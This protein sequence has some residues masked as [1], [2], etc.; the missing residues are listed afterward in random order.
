MS[1]PGSTSINV[2]NWCIISKK[3]GELRIVNT[4]GQQVRVYQNSI[5]LDI[6]FCLPVI[7]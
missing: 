5:P 2:G 7:W 6:F 4:D 3:E 1:K